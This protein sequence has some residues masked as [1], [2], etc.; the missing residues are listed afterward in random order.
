METARSRPHHSQR[1]L[2]SRAVWLG[3]NGHPGVV[4][5][6]CCDQLPSAQTLHCLPAA[7]AA[8]DG[9]VALAADDAGVD[10]PDQDTV[11]AAAAMVPPVGNGDVALGGWPR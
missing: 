4:Q 2:A 1:L 8:A 11:L 3:D 9:A 10:N 6:P 5:P 7:P